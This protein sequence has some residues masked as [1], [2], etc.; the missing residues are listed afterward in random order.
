[1]KKSYPIILVFPFR[2]GYEA[3]LWY[4]MV[5]F[6]PNLEKTTKFHIIDC[7]ELLLY[8]PLSYTH[9]SLPALF[10][11]SRNCSLHRCNSISCLHKKITLIRN[12]NNSPLKSS[13]IVGKSN[14]LTNL[15]FKGLGNWLISTFPVF[16]LIWYLRQIANTKYLRI[17]ISEINLVF[18]F[19]PSML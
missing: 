6:V 11:S 12:V 8:L 19:L 1:M 15:L 4:I 18:L 9:S 2:V 5:F 14:L 10:L 13:F 17:S 16:I 3:H 7:N